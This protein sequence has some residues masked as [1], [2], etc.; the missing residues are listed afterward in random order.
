MKMKLETCNS[1]NQSYLHHDPPEFPWS[2][3]LK[4]HLL[5]QDPWL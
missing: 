4:R 3:I 5:K 1:N 2:W